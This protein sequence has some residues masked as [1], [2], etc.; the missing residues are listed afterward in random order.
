[1]RPW[2]ALSGRGCI[3]NSGVPVCGLSVYKRRS[4]EQRCVDGLLEAGSK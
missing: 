1:M 3:Q 4:D 2:T